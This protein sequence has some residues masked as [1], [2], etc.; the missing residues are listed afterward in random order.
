MDTTQYRDAL[1]KLNMS[2]EGARRFFRIGKRTSHAYVSG[3]KAVPELIAVVLAL[4]LTYGVSPVQARLMAGLPV[5]NYRDRR[6][7][8]IQIGR[9]RRFVGKPLT[10]HP[11]GHNSGIEGD[12]AED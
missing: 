2:Q 3:Q 7:G 1:A 6:R 8:R 12:I 9:P 4:M 11:P 5:E 10:E